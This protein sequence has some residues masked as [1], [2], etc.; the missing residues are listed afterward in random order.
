MKPKDT[1][2]RLYVYRLDSRGQ[3]H[4]GRNPVTDPALARDFFSWLYR[5]PD[6][7]WWLECEGEK[8]KVTVEDAPQFVE[9]I[10]F[11]PDPADPAGKLA[12]IDLT[13]GT[14]R[15]EP[16]DPGTLR[17]GKN[18]AL[19]CRLRSGMEAKFHRAPQLEL[20]RWVDDELNLR[21]GGVAYPVRET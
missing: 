17:S 18:G 8:C 19:Y 5:E 10:R 16:L 9:S 20:A 7:S 2:G 13:V 1:S 21:I 15:S 12:G 3:W 14:G 6:G 11:H 4:Y